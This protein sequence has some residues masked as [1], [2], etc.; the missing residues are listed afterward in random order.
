MK[1]KISVCIPAY[2]R[3]HMIGA[4]IRSVLAQDF[5]DFEIVV[6]DNCST[7]DTVAVARGFGDPRIKVFQNPHNLGMYP[8]FNK[9]IEAAE[10]QYIKFLLSDDYF[11]TRQALSRYAEVLDRH[12]DVG[13]VT[14]AYISV[15]GDDEL[16]GAACGSELERETDRFIRGCLA[17]GEEGGR[18]SV[19]TVFMDAR[20]LRIGVENCPIPDR[21]YDGRRILNLIY[22]SGT[23]RFVLT[24]THA[25]FRKAITREVGFFNEQVDGGW[26]TETEYWTRILYRSDLYRIGYPLVAFRLHEGSGTEYVMKKRSQYRDLLFYYN[27][28]LENCGDVIPW[29][30]RLLGRLSFNYNIIKHYLRVRAA[31][32]AA[33]AEHL[34]WALRADAAHF[35]LA[36]ATFPLLSL[37]KRYGHDAF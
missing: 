21:R 10:G 14:C 8:N 35:L 15:N 36:A 32:S 2:N 28:M 13:L 12:A 11:V 27:M 31:G 5:E 37:A 34:G 4:T 26:G 20:G 22:R 18:I 25:C 19:D 3:A 6:S 9:C 30:N 17:R 29:R 23:D 7:D 24:P 16:S 33:S 1:P